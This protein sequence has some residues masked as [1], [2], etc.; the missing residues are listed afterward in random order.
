[1]K[2]HLYFARRFLWIFL[3]LLT[4]FFLLQALIDLI[5]QVRRL[6]GTEAS[7]ADIIGLTLLGT[8]ESINQILP[9]VMI[10]STVALFVSL[11]R[12]SELVVVRAV[13]RS[14]LRAL[15][16]PVMVALIIGGLAVTMMNPIVAATS[17]R[18]HELFQGY[19]TGSDDVLSISSE[20]LW[21]RQGG[22]EGQT[23]IRAT[24]ANPHATVLYDVT[25]LSYAPGG[26]PV[27]RI[28]AE[29]AELTDGAWLLRDAKTWPLAGGAN[30]EAAA[31]IHDRMELPSTL[32]QDRIRDSF[33]KPNAISVWDLPRFISQ[34]EQAGFSARRHLVWLQMELARPLFLVAMVLIGAAFTMRHVRAGGIG[35]AVLVS[36]L[37]GFGLYY[38]RNFAQIL[39]ENGQIPVFLA[40]W[41][42]PMAAA[43]LGMGLLLHTEDG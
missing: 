20:G 26:G 22:P 34:L 40:A 21:L 25:F 30:P 8:P 14:G 35:V 9:L 13:G 23:V 17:K 38:I 4:V 31:Q 3:G 12:S 27:T 28:E 36:L 41:A 7:M 39:G 43:M 15:L 10:L 29:E 32:T 5:E 2:L 1:M 24:S 18:Y 16:A 6:D 11:A 42:P 33:G 37:L 19:K